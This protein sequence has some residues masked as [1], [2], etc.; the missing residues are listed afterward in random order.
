MPRKTTHSVLSFIGKRILLLVSVR[1]QRDPVLQM[2]LACYQFECKERVYKGCGPVVAAS[3]KGQELEYVN[4][5]S[6]VRFLV[7]S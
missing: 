7:I 6:T 1:Q 2:F 3:R 5:A 4:N